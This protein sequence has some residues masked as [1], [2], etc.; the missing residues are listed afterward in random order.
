MFDKRILFELD[1]N[2]R[3]TTSDIGKMLKKSKQF[4]DYRIKKLED[5]KILLGYTTVIEHA[6]L[7]YRSSRV[8]FKFRNI[9]PEKQKE[10]EKDLIK[11]KEV[12]WLVTLEGQ[13]DV[14]Y[15]MAISTIV[16]FY[17]YWDVLM[18][19]YRKYISNRYVVLY[20]HVRQYP[21]S[22]LI[23]KKNMDSGTIVGKSKLR[24]PILTEFDLQLLKVLS[25]NGRMPLLTLASHM[26]TSPQVVKNHITILTKKEI[27]QGYRAIIDIS[28][29]G[30]RYF[31]VFMN[32]VH[33]ERIKE[34]LQ[35]IKEHPNIVNIDRTIGGA[36]VE[37]EIQV[38]SFDEFDT[39]IKGMRSHFKG[40]I[41]TVD[42]VI[43]G[44]EKKMNYFPFKY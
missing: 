27:I 8:Y 16:D 39:I 41:D 26:K 31:R 28:K 33:T 32:L 4:V 30:Y 44:K 12:W 18:D 3:I 29:L 42:F 10:L 36:D 25:S 43:V 9:T 13:W 19:K 15:A 34:L 40:M 38:K 7:G 17:K 14:G 1:K 11:D 22:Y 5:Q 23:D 20:T 2:A 21:K 24:D 6:K 37:I 35:Y